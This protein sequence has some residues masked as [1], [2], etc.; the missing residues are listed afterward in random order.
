M[1]FKDWYIE[2]PAVLNQ[3]VQNQYQ[4]DILNEFSLPTLTKFNAN[5][6]KEVV[7]KADGS[8]IPSQSPV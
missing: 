8:G 7:S 6:K 2:D 1:Y 3:V 4:H 5:L